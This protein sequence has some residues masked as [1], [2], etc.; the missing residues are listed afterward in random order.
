MGMTTPLTD[1]EIEEIDGAFANQESGN[2]INNYQPP[3]I[4]YWFPSWWPG[5]GADVD[6]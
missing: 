5:G 3:V 1:E 4:D 6:G 2:N